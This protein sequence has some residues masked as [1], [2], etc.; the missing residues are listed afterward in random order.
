MKWIGQDI[1]DQI[2]RFRN[3]V[4]LED[5]STTTETTALVVDSDGKIS[6][7]VTSGVNLANGADNR[8]V[9]AV[10]T[11]GLN[12]EASL[13]FDGSILTTPALDVTTSAADG[14][15][16]IRFFQSSTRRA[17]I[18]LNDINNNL[19]I[20]S[21]YGKLELYAAGT[22]GADSEAAYFQIAP[23]GIF[24]FGAADSDATLTSDGNMIFRI[25]ADNDE[26]GQSFAFQNNASTEI[27]SLN[28]SGDLQ[29]DG[30]LTM[31][32]TA[33]LTN[34]GLLSVANQS[35]ITGLGTI[36]SG[37]WNGTIIG[38][39]YLDANTA[40]L[41][42]DQTFTGVKTFG[43]PIISDGNRTL[44]SGDGAAIH[45]DTFDV[46]DGT[47]SA[48]G[49]ISAF[50]HVAIEAPRL[51]ATNS[52]VTTTN[53]S[54]LYIKGPPVVGTNQTITNAYALLVDAGNVK[55]DADL[56][57]GGD[58]DLE[59]DID[60]NGTLETDALTVGGTNV[61]T[62]SLITTLGTISAGVWQGTAIN[63]TYLVGQSGTNTGDQTS[64]SGN[65]GTATTLA[66]ARA[67][68][69]VNFNGSAAITIPTPRV[70]GTYIKLLPID[71]MPND[72]GGTSKGITLNDSGTTGMK[73]GV[74]AME[75]VA[76][77]D[78]PEGFTA[79]HVDIY[80]N[81]PDLAIN[82]F[83]MNI[84]ASGMA[85]KG[86]GNANT[87][88]DMTDVESTVTNFLAVRV[89]TT[90]TSERVFG[91]RITIAPN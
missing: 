22:D 44:A 60:V 47:T 46:T 56:I 91:G 72:D 41:S 39:V 52:S 3:D 50:N 15:P 9:T 84:G 27:A 70:W 53:A 19:R 66:T 24:R 18:Q 49:T 40:H 54:T 8:V 65:A 55:I 45:V 83:E 17:F 57:V 78:I 12:A 82:V 76:I 30:T 29:I 85:A 75:L 69:G 59:G 61:L 63:Q 13:T 87:T 1:Y 64:V 4:Y 38:D 67:I 51:L 90:G 73:P 37:V 88:L 77:V 71:F 79:T 80:D 11:N 68:N 28:E 6:K 35:N 7:N 58:I 26:T 62:G 89:E 14:S 34:A 23:T 42:V 48:S 32:N 25:D 74:A 86:T 5:L 81:S 33:T 10:G 36:S 2:A 20:A 31:G 43:K 16:L 21:E